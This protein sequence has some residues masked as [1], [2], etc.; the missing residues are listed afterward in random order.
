MQICD[1]KKKGSTT[2]DTHNAKAM[3]NKVGLSRG[4]HANVVQL[5][6]DDLKGIANNNVENDRCKTAMLFQA[7]LR[8]YEL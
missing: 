3:K 2:T 6:V 4:V 5:P 7:Q 8:G 1:R